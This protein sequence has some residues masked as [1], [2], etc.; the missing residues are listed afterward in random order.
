MR[1][2]KKKNFERRWEAVGAF[3][4]H[5][6]A[7]RRGQWAEQFASGAPL[8]VE[9][10]CGKGSYLIESARRRPEA[11]FVGCERV[12]EVLLMSMERAARQELTNLRCI[13]DD[14]EHIEE[15]FAPGEVSRLHIHFC[16]PWSSGKKAKRRLTHHNFLARYHRILAPEGE[17]HFKTDNE[18]L[19]S[20]SQEELAAHGFTILFSS[21]DWHH[22]ESYPGDDIMTEYET[23]FSEQ[24]LPIYRLVAR[25]A[26]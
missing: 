16:D 5:E 23:R 1:V 9:L 19:F 13:G 12:K 25:R 11:F 4:E 2:R 7:Q 17:I 24:G 14:I 20:F 8:I 22:E 18:G 10:G 3:L 15:W 21:T 26:E 6:P